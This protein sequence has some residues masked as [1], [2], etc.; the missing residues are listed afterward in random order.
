MKIV[1]EIP[2]TFKTWI[3]NFKGVDLPIGD[4]ANDIGR[5]EN[6]P[7]TED[8]QVVLSENQMRNHDYSSVG[9]FGT[10]VA[11]F[12]FNLKLL[13]HPCLSVFHPR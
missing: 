3:A 1:K 8:Y 4:Y 9:N 6:F 10:V 5:D 7:D 13:V 2:W 11:V 12:S